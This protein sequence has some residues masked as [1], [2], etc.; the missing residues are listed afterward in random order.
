MKTVNWYDGRKERTEIACDHLMELIKH[1][2]D[3]NERPLRELFANY[4]TE[5]SNDLNAF[6]LILSRFNLDVSN[7]LLKHRIA[8]NPENKKLVK[9]ILALSELRYTY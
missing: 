2:N 3:S 5:F 4:V 7:C 9:E 6:P 1:L 8:L